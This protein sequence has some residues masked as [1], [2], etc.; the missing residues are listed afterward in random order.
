LSTA[1]GDRSYLFENRQER[2]YVELKELLI[3]G[4]FA[5]GDLVYTSEIAKQF[6]VSSMPVRDAM[7]GLASD[8]AVE[9]LPQRGVRIPVRSEDELLE[10]GRLRILLETQLCA[11]AVAN[12]N[13]RDVDELLQCA[14]EAEA[15]IDANEIDRYLWANKD[16][17]FFIYRLAAQPVTLSLD[18][19]LWLRIG[20]TIRRYV[21]P[22]HLEDSRQ[23]HRA[24][25]EAMVNHEV[26]AA[27]QHLASDIA[28]PLSALL[29]LPVATLLP[30]GRGLGQ[31]HDRTQDDS[32]GP[33]PG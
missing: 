9:I 5:P 28:E 3:S 18:E 33:T 30:L 26:A 19:Q 15:A 4:H 29:G 20:P 16:F 22:D 27:C 8:G 31:V 23:R 7:R 14:R 12:L 1:L 24:I 25:V 32:A 21:T 17:H 2:I 6:G 10:I 11:H 13:A